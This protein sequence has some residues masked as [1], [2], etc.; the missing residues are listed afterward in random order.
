MR[1][2]TRHAHGHTAARRMPRTYHTR[3]QCKCTWRTLSDEI[4]SSSGFL[5]GSSS[6]PG[7]S[8]DSISPLMELANGR[9]CSIILSAPFS[10][11]A[12][13]I[14]MALVILAV[15]RTDFIRMPIALMD[16][17]VVR[18][19]ATRWGTRLETLLPEAGEFGPAAPRN[20]T[21]PRWGGPGGAGS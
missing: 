9:A 6:G 11:D 4:A 19:P 2:C 16:G 13:T 18:Q 10:L 14:F 20:T 21:R 17:M 12:A 5:V 15:D 8:F 7:V 1:I 3:A